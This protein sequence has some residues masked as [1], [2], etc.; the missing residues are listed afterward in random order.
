MLPK[1][2]LETT[3][4]SYLT[5][6]PSKDVTAAHQQLTHEWWQNRKHD[7]DLFSSQLVVEESSAGDTTFAQSRLQLLTGIPLLMVNE[8]CVS[9][10]RALVEFGPIPEKAAVDA[11]HIAIA[12]VQALTICSLGIA[13]TSL[14]RKCRPR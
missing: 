3:V 7:F 4:I 5:A 1:I 2:Y 6:R 10:G 8:D 13:S 9:L 14:T 12:T 11:L